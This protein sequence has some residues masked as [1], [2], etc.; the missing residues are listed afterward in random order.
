MTYTKWYVGFSVDKKKRENNL[1]DCACFRW[2]HNISARSRLHEVVVT[3]IL[4]GNLRWPNALPRYNVTLLRNCVFDLIDWIE[5]EWCGNVIGN[6]NPFEWMSVNNQFELLMVINMLE[7]E[8]IWENG[9]PYISTMISNVSGYYE[10]GH[11]KHFTGH[12]NR[13]FWAIIMDLI[14][15]LRLLND[16]AAIRWQKLRIKIGLGEG[17]RLYRICICGSVMVLWQSVV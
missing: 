17:Y 12:I 6:W 8:L 10:R 2:W 1:C 9:A 3:L 13:I 4:N 14:K 16:Q 11:W 5:F 7:I 15:I